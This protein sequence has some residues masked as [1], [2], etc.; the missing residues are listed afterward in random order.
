MRTASVLSKSPKA[1]SLNQPSAQTRSLWRVWSFLFLSSRHA[2][3][4]K[5]NARGRGEKGARS[6]PRLVASAA[7]SRGR[8]CG[9]GSNGNRERSARGSSSQ[10]WALLRWALPPRSF[11][12]FAGA[13]TPRARDVPSPAMRW[14]QACPTRAHVRSGHWAPQLANPPLLNPPLLKVQVLSSLQAPRSK[15]LVLLCPA[16]LAVSAFQNASIHG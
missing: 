1:A 2:T 10:A 15:A 8:R 6:S 16:A 4:P 7:T 11:L 9:A 5:A 12:S 13:R 14:P 3:R